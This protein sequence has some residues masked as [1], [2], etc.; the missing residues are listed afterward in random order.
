MLYFEFY[1]LQIPFFLCHIPVKAAYEFL[2]QGSSASIL[3]P[4]GGVSQLSLIFTGKQP[5]FHLCTT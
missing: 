1:R 2:I 4:Q 3:L 5:T